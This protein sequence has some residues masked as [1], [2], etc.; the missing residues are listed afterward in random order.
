MKLSLFLIILTIIP[1]TLTF[2]ISPSFVVRNKSNLLVSLS[3]ESND[4][5]VRL[6]DRD[7]PAAHAGL[8]N[9]LYGDGEV[10][11]AESDL[12]PPPLPPSLRAG[13][14][15]TQCC[16]RASRGAAAR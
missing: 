14:G 4:G 3:T 8:H 7:V 6:E 16:S 12:P 15:I 10:H 13:S 5:E 1:Q 9:D 2:N 11:G